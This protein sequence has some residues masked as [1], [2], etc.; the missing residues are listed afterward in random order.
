MAR[1][2]KTY[3]LKVINPALA[4]EWHPTKNGKLLP[5][6]VT[7]NTHKKAWWLCS[8]GH[9]WQAH[10]SN[11]NKGRGCPYC[12]GKL[13]C[14]DNCLQTID[15][16]LSKEWHPTKNGK[17]T[18]NNI[19]PG[20][21]KKVWWQ[22]KR[23]HE[24]QTTVA[25]RSVGRGCPYC[26]SQTSIMEL[27]LYSEMSYL[28]K[29]I[30]HRDKQFGV[31]CD[32]YIPDLKFAVEVDGGYWHRDKYKIDVL[33]TKK[34]NYN[35]IRILRLR[36]QGLKKISKDDIIFSRKDEHLDIVKK[37][38]NIILKNVKIT[39]N[40]LR[41]RL[42][43]YLH[44]TTFSNEN[45][46]NRLRDML[47]SPLPGTSLAETHKSLAKEWHSTRNENLTP[48]DVAYGSELKVWWQCKAG[49]EWQT[50]VNARTMG[51]GCPYCSGQAVNKDNCLQTV[52]P[53][54]SKEW[55]PVKNGSLSP[56]DVTKGY[57]KKVWWK[58]KKGHEW[59]A[60]PNTRSQGHGCPYCSG[61][62]AYKD[63]CLQTINPSLVKEW[64]P[65]KNG[66]LT[67]RNVMP[68]SG[69]KAWWKCKE[70][71]EWEA[72]IAHRTRGSGCP[73]C[74]GQAVCKDNCLQTINPALAKEWHPTKNGNLTP[75]DVTANSGQK[76]W[77]ICRKNHIWIASIYSRNQGRGCPYCSGK[78]VSQDNCLASRNPKLAKEW[79]PIK[80]G[81][82]TPKNVTFGSNKKVWWKCKKGHEWQASV[83]NRNRGRGCPYCARLH[84][85]N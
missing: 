28:F 41:N 49:H 85:E 40:G 22:C 59:Q 80:N 30:K 51:R 69:R 39:N 71:H 2:S 75:K 47:P 70:G 37:V 38:V 54:L 64:H 79:H 18:P 16:K 11:R 60:S 21:N 15:P 74:S 31:E 57:I 1:V 10:I 3:N 8:S 36:E 78:M 72:V 62:F 43:T 45:E 34:I 63:T 9:E 76:V 42:K 25:N 46:F 33:K 61:N 14:K 17:L 12:V 56:K 52:N 83:G 82:L 81:K 7:P 26:H 73:F 35:G 6:D 53:A 44:T 68:N 48:K 27:R 65:T 29:K 55:H 24:W 84:R 67:P 66:N 32:I 19:T 5:S 13:V 58:C 23:G 77:W 20:S 4:K 50:T